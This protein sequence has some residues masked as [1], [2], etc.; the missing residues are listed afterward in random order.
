M[1]R[2]R[3]LVFLLVWAAFGAPG[4]GYAQNPP[5]QNPSLDSN[6]YFP[7]IGNS[8]EMDTLSGTAEGQEIGALV[9]KN[10][11]PKPDGSYG[12][13][14]IDNLVP[15]PPPNPNTNYTFSQFAT[16]RNFNLH[17]LNQQ[18]QRLNP[19]PDWWSGFD[20]PRFIH[21]RDRAHLDLFVPERTI[22]LAD[23]AGN[24]DST[25]FVT[26][27]SSLHG[28]LPN[29]YFENFM[30][31]YAARLTNDT[32][33][34]IVTG[35]ITAWNDPTKDTTFLLLFK[36]RP[37]IKGGDMI[38]EDTSCQLY[39]NLINNPYR[40]SIEGDFRGTGREDLI[41][42]ID[43]SPGMPGRYGDL[44]FY[45]NDPPFTLEK[46]AFALNYDTLLTGWQNPHLARSTGALVPFPAPVFPNHAK[47]HIADLIF[48]IQIDTEF[49]LNPYVGDLYFFRCGPG[50][51]SHRIT[52]DSAAYI[53]K[54]PKIF[55]NTYWPLDITD[56]GDMTGT[57]NHVLYTAAGVTGY[58]WDAFFVMGA[59]LDDKI[60]IYNRYEWSSRAGDTLTANDDSLEDFL[61]PLTDPNYQGGTPSTVGTLWLY[62][63]SKQIPVRLNPKFADVRSIPQKNGA[64]IEFSPNPV[65][66]G[67][68]V[69]TIVWPEAENA[70]YS[71]YDML[72]R[73]CQH[74]PIR[75]LGGP[76]QQRIYFSSLSAGTYFYN[77]TGARHTANARIVK[78]G[79]NESSGTPAP[80]FIQSLR[81][82]RDGRRMPEQLSPTITR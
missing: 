4:M 20:N 15:P 82:A 31:A 40:M 33:D 62:Y 45:A 65:T 46:L 12:S 8:S 21:F 39:P 18:R 22:Y 70:E 53:I 63:G 71:V 1:K 60:D 81:D 24:Y 16:G 69:A 37:N 3:S 47:D 10:L 26:L 76:E 19:D 66:S 43:S 41:S 61:E 25:R 49:A 59:A 77:I 23:D 67:W 9:V 27:L 5:F 7:Q 28:V 56:A 54:C 17:Q 29:N 38:Y 74:G 35:I 55:S 14:L 73:L 6:C 42:A 68:S 44:F 58:A 11:G 72:G 48:S 80:S 50:F 30:P 64:A 79:G 13:I 34:D 51:G 52:I 36:G 78:L 57:G 32:L 75:L 2:L